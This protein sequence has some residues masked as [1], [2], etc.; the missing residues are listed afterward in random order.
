[1]LNVKVKTKDIR[2]SIPVPYFFLDLGVFIVSSDFLNKQI[3]KWTKEHMTEKEK[4]MVFAIPPLN[5]QELKKI[6]RELKRN[7][8]LNIVDVNAKD[9]T[10]VFIRL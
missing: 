6:V 1:M 8:G 7:R 3:N 10:E 9:G 4:E 5:K 2:F